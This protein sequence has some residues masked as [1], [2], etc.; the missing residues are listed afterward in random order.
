MR[1][2]LAFV[3]PGGPTR[4]VVVTTE[5]NAAVGDIAQALVLRDP[6]GGRRQRSQPLTLTVSPPEGGPGVT[7]PAERAHRG[8]GTRHTSTSGW[9]ALGRGDECVERA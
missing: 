8:P 7:V 4:N 5:A 2:K 9:P 6:A 1:L 3:R